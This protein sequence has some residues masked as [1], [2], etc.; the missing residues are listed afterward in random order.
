[1]TLVDYQKSDPIG[2]EIDKRMIK[3]RASSFLEGGASIPRAARA[4]KVIRI[5]NDIYQ[6]SINIAV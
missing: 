1:M 5:V 3:S 4:L 2:S 6:K